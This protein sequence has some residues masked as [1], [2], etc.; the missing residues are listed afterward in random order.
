[1]NQTTIPE[2][3]EERI[4]KTTITTDTPAGIITFSG[5]GVFALILAGLSLAFT[6]VFHIGAG[7]L[8]Y[9]KFQSFGWAILD[10]IFAIFYY[11]YYAIFLNRSS[12]IESPTESVIGGGKNKK[13]LN[14]Y[15]RRTPRRLTK[16]YA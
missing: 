9:A 3:E 14:F 8:S 5:M 4:R 6:I 1:M 12:T 2:S 13:F 11:P 7:M 10:T 15:K 16:F